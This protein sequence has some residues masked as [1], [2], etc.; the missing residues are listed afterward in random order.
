[1]RV[2]TTGRRRIV[3]H[4]LALSV[5]TLIAAMFGPPPVNAFQINATFTGLDAGTQSVIN[6]AIAFYESTFADP[7]VIDIEFH[8]LPSG[9]ELGHSDVTFYDIGY[10]LYRDRLISDA[11]SADDATAISSLPAMATDPVLGKP[12]VLLRSAN[13]R[14]LSPALPFP[15]PGLLLDFPGSPCPTFT[16]DG[17][18][19]LNLT[20]I[21]SGGFS[22]LAT[23]EHEIDEVL[24]LASSLRFDGIVDDQL[25]VYDLFRYAGAGV[26]SF[27]R[28]ASTSE[29]CAAGTPQAFFSI[30]GGNTLLNEFNNCN[31]GGDYGD[32]IRHA[33]PQVQDA[34]ANPGSPFLTSTSVE[35]R[36]L[37]VI[38]YTL[39]AVPAPASVVLLGVG[40]AWLAGRR[41][42][43]RDA[44]ARV[45]RRAR[46]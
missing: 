21:A 23:V 40:L 22:L 18:I 39:V 16:G 7:V 2:H 31:N 13:A 27:A 5:M 34:F 9:S 35:I 26:R 3:H 14:A 6:Q 1:M 42:S 33:T 20:D 44:R 10:S 4:L 38:G 41:A 36:A 24:G 25:F 11:T 46:V 30:D 45:P 19:G 8:T 28:N 12:L 32:W 37:D 43:G 29:P 15:A 17:C